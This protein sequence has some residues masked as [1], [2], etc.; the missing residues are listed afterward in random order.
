MNTIDEPRI[1]ASNAYRFAR[2]ESDD[3]ASIA[4]S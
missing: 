1:V 2:G 3:S 4:R